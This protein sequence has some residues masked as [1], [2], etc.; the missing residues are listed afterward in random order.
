MLK[1]LRT[2]F[3]FTIVA[4]AALLS[5]AAVLSGGLLYIPLVVLAFGLNVWALTQ[6]EREGFFGDRNMPRAGDPERQFHPIQTVILIVL[7]FLQV[8]I[9]SFHILAS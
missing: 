7:M 1:Q 4:L 2:E 8:A 3:I 5:V 9:T 6:S